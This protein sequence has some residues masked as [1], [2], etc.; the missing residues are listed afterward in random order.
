MLDPVVIAIITGAAGNVVAYM[1]NGEVDTLRAWARRIFG[2]GDQA[3]SSAQVLAIEHDSAALT[4]GT[5]SKEEAKIRWKAI[6]ETYLSEHPEVRPEIEALASSAVGGTE[7]MYVGTQRNEQ[8]G[9][10]IGRDNY[11]EISRPRRD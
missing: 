4:Q 10:F 7:A 5:M 2:R 3:A 11:G 6:F 8:D 1:L 9:I